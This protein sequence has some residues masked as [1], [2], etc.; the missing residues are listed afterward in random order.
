[1]SKLKA[2][3]V[4]CGSKKGAD[5][6]YQAAAVELGRQMVARN[7]ALVFGGGRIGIMGILAD[8]ILAGGGEVIGVIPDFLMQLE[9]G[10]E[11]VT[12]LIQVGSMHE[13]KATMFS[14][15]DAFAILP[16]GLGTLDECFEIITWKQ[17][18]LHSKPIVVLNVNGCWNAF[19]Q[20]VD[21]V[22][23][24][25][26]AHPK[27][28]DLFSVVDCVDDIFEAIDRAPEPDPVVLEDHL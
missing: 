10:N 9:V 18:Q 25:G 14:R 19:G 15:A 21:D 16:G 13:R 5:P 6:A 11:N 28:K 8:A 17:L 1:M 26:F 20:L 22:I 7:I 27:A 2:L 24:A 3:A 4:F 12:E 23:A